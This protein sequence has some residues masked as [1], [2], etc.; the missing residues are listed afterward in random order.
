MLEKLLKKWESII[1]GRLP[2][3]L[4]DDLKMALTDDFKI[5]HFNVKNLWLFVILISNLRVTA[6]IV[7]SPRYRNGT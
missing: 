6:L 1:S 2:Q 4:T 5:D 3:A 7:L